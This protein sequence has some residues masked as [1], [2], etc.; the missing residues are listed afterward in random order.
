MHRN[1]LIINEFNSSNIGDKIINSCMTR[2]VAKV[3]TTSTIYQIPASMSAAT[4]IKSSVLDGTIIDNERVNNT[5]KS[6]SKFKRRTINLISKFNNSTSY[7]M[8]HKNN[9]NSIMKS[10]G[11]VKFDHVIIGGGQ[12][13][14]DY[15]GFYSTLRRILESINF[16]SCIILG[17]GVSKGLSEIATRE[18]SRLLYNRKVL[19]VITRDEQSRANFHY[20][21]PE[22]S[23]KCKSFLPDIAYAYTE[24]HALNP[25]VKKDKNIGFS[26]MQ[27][28]DFNVHNPG[29]DKCIYM[30]LLCNEMNK[31]PRY[32]WKLI[33]S[34]KYDYAFLSELIDYYF[35]TYDKC[36]KNKTLVLDDMNDSRPIHTYVESIMSCVKI[37][38][39]RLHAYIVS[40]SLNIPAELL[41]HNP[42]FESAS[43]CKLSTTELSKSYES[44]LTQ[45]VAKS[46]IITRGAK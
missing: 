44:I 2:I 42:K 29:I 7:W 8:A 27:Y 16:D 33:A 39:N 14:M 11:N 34:T 46:R 26:F 12:L 19:S 40:R 38:S 1:V 6:N 13:F 20:F 22:I 36:I 17:V 9:F 31:Y 3:F 45:Y 30:N 21:G 37:I 10:I 25:S 4:Y 43:K 15:A 28:N 24:L 23:Y 41:D 5:I 32:K 35:N 18:F